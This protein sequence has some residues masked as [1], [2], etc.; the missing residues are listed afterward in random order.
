MVRVGKVFNP[1]LCI[2]IREA[3]AVFTDRGGNKYV[4]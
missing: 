4:Q 1:A 3:A 2:E